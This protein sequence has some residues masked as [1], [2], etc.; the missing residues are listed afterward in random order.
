L[1]QVGYYPD[2]N[3]V[4]VVLDTSA[5]FFRILE[6]SGE[7]AF[8][9]ELSE[10]FAYTPSEEKTRLA[11]FSEL[12]KTGSYRLVAGHDTSYL[13]PIQSRCFNQVLKASI[14]S[15]FYQRCSYLLQSE[16]AGQWY[17]LAG[18]PD[19]FLSVLDSPSEKTYDVSGGWYDAGDYAKY[20]VNAGITCA[21]LMSLYELCPDVIG[22]DHC[23]PESGNHKSDLLDEVKYELD[24]LLR[25]QDND[26][27]V[28]FKVG[29]VEWSWDV[30]PDEDDKVRYI[31]GKS[32]TSTL[33][34]TSVMAMASRIYKSYDQVFAARCGDAAEKSWGWA[35]AN[36]S[37]VHPENVEGTGPYEDGKDLK[38][39]DEFF[40]AAT[41][42]YLATNKQQYKDSVCTMLS[43]RKISASAWWQDVNNLGFFSLATNPNTLGDSINSIVKKEIVTYADTLVNRINSNG[44]RVS[45][46]TRDYTW[47][48]TGNAGNQ[49]VVLVYAHK[50]T[51]IRR[52]LDALVMTNDYLLGKNPV[53][54]SYIP[55]WFTFTSSTTQ[56]PMRAD[57]IDELFLGLL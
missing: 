3:K 2:A 49:G 43:T 32:T 47:G 19:S 41:E 1:N 5:S 51:G 50:L 10:V 11:D 22:D 57:F 25:M 55:V 45:M 48:S 40:W 44:Y 54:Y 42:L 28:F 9:G 46:V 6:S 36:P 14:R 29:P 20:V 13:F 52:Y 4:A 17:R 15:Y 27:G 30:M 38:Y 33:C 34:F 23:I 26:G 8:S 56:S 7:V 21:T 24:W 37:V 31:I 16:F 53:G 18:H 12:K 35:C 39:K